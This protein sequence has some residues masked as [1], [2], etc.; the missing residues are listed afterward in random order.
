MTNDRRSGP[1]EA[2]RKPFAWQPLTPRGVAAFAGASL[3]RL[4]LVEVVVALIAAGAV[5]WFCSSEWFP[6]VRQAIRQLPEQG[7]I[8][9][10]ELDASIAGPRVLAENPPFILLILD[11]ERSRNASQT[12]DVV[13]ELHKTNF[14]ICSIFG[15]LVLRY[16]KGAAVEFNRAAMAALWGAWEPAL[17]AIAGAG[18]MLFLLISWSLLATLYCV[19]VRL[20]GFFKDRELGWRGSWYLASA[21]LMPGALL[22]TAGVWAYG[23][24]WKIDLIRLLTLFIVHFVVGWAYLAISP[25][26]VPSLTTLLPRGANPFA[27]SPPPPLEKPDLNKEREGSD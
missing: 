6:A 15:C 20:L 19:L 24:R 21:S 4:I 23:L 26:F 18:V 22:L 8:H 3:A 27:G 2:R 13:I 16:P 12:S 5:M 9:N 14:Q 7:A 17:L 11:P 1:S 25:L 10:Q